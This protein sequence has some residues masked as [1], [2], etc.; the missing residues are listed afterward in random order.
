L[1]PVAGP[2]VLLCEDRMQVH[3]RMQTLIDPAQLPYANLKHNQLFYMKV[4]FQSF[5]A[6]FAV[7][8]ASLRGN[9]QILKLPYL[10]FGQFLLE[11]QFF[12]VGSR[13]KNIQSCQ[14]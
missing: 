3:F 7:I 12:K 5:F 14:P 11:L 10:V 8:S 6:A 4:H 2:E 9:L 1:E 13:N